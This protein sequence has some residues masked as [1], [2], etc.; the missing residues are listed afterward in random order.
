MLPLCVQAQQPKATSTSANQV[1]RLLMPT[2]RAI[3]QRRQA[4]LSGEARLQNQRAAGSDVRDVVSASIAAYH[5]DKL[6]TGA[7]AA[8]D[9]EAVPTV[10]ESLQVRR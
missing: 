7:S 1:W 9:S 2:N 6:I 3:S 5:M 8:Q 4:E 10:P